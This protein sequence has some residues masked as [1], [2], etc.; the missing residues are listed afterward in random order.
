MTFNCELR[1]S[2]FSVLSGRF[3]IKLS[4]IC[5]LC[6]YLDQII[7]QQ[8]LMFCFKFSFTMFLLMFFPLFSKVFTDISTKIYELPKICNK[9]LKKLF[10]I[11]IY[12]VN[13][14]SQLHLASEFYWKCTLGIKTL[15]WHWIEKI[16]G[17]KFF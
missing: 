4:K 1:E 2:Q 16:L 7:I 10:T 14:I 17:R 12:K 8:K 3:T 15:F 6:T 9:I 5:F 13:S 11:I